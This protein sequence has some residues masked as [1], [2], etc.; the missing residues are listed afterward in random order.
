L[1]RE[2]RSLADPETGVAGFSQATRA[3]MH[4]I[5]IPPAGPD[6]DEQTSPSFARRAFAA[7]CTGLALCVAVGVIS[8]SLH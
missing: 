7:V 2:R 3:H 8:A 1:S 4:Q 6:R 5:I